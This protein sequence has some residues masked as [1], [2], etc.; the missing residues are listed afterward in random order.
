MNQLSFNSESAKKFVAVYNEAV[1][2]KA[3]IFKY[4]GHD[5]VVSY[6]YYMI[7]H[8]CNNYILTGIFREDRTFT[9]V[10]NPNLN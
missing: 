6:A 5:V 8:L 7:Q 4:E 2:S 3:E 10:T 9:F 1:K